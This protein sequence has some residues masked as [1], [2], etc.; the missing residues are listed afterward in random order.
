[1]IIFSTNNRTEKLKDMGTKT[2]E[3]VIFPCFNA[4]EKRYFHLKEER[5]IEDYGPNLQRIRQLA[6]I[7]LFE[8]SF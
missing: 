1:M 2:F 3:N 8:I 4:R 6:A 7:L 5:M